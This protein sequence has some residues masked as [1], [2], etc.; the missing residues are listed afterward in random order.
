MKWFDNRN[1][2]NVRHHPIYRVIQILPTTARPWL[3]AL[4]T[5]AEARERRMT[6]KFQRREAHLLNEL[7]R[8]K[9]K[10]RG[11]L[12]LGRILFAAGLT[13]LASQLTRSQ[14][15]NIRSTPLMKEKTKETATSGK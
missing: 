15:G 2:K 4:E 7:N 13:F 8:A 10:K 9:A 12:G 5:L 6:N 11:G 1:V 14:Q 3:L